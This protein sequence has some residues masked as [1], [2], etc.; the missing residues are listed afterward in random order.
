MGGA[1]LLPSPV[2]VGLTDLDNVF[3]RTSKADVYRNKMSAEECQ[4][5]TSSATLTTNRKFQE[6]LS[7]SSLRTKQ[8]HVTLRRFHPLYIP[9]RPLG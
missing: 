2:V 1:E 5:Y 3:D 8:R 4:M 7:L 9:Q 6:A